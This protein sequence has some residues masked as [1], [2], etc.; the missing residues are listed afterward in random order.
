M[1]TP[2]SLA[3]R[4]DRLRTRLRTEWERA[5][6]GP[7]K[8]SNLAY[9]LAMDLEVRTGEDADLIIQRLGEEAVADA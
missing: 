6:G 1:P 4:E 7:V 2:L 5:Q 8:V 9:G 3:E